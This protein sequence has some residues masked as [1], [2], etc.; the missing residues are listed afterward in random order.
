MT[1]PLTS[2]PNHPQESVAVNESTFTQIFGVMYIT[3]TSLI[4]LM[5]PASKPW[6]LLGKFT[7]LVVGPLCW[8]RGPS[9]R[10]FPRTP[11]GWIPDIYRQT[12]GPFAC[13]ILSTWI[14]LWTHKF[15]RVPFKPSLF[16]VHPRKHTSFHPLARTKVIE[17]ISRE[18]KWCTVPPRLFRNKYNYLSP[19]LVPMTSHPT[20]RPSCPQEIATTAD[21]TF[22]QMLG[23]LYIALTGLVGSIFLFGP[24]DWVWLG[25]LHDAKLRP[26]VLAWSIIILCYQVSSHP[27][28]GITLWPDSPSAHVK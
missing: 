20:L 11:T 10:K 6:A 4:D 15:Y 12:R 22:T 21:V 18:G 9:T 7:N 25:G 17:T 3:L 28:V 1:P 2:R 19:Y 8:A 16:R 14:T 26:L 27:M 13:V 24:S 5:V 23:V